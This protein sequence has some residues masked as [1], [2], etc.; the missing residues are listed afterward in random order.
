[1]DD[2]GNVKAEKRDIQC[3]LFYQTRYL[4]SG[5]HTL[6]SWV[7]LQCVIVLLPDHTHLLF[8]CDTRSSFSGISKIKTC[9]KQYLAAQK[10][11]RPLDEFLPVWQ[12]G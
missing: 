11:L 10:L 8:C 7:G 1:M 2:V 4:Y 6:F 3:T 12:L 9:W 5:E